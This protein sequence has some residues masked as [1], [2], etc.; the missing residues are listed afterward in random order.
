MAGLRRK[1]GDFWKG[2]EEWDVFVLSETWQ[3]EREWEWL[4][5]KLPR[6]FVWERQWAKRDNKKGR[7]RGG[8]LMRVRKGLE[9]RGEGR[10]EIE[11]IL[12][13]EVRMGRE[14]WRIVGVYINK[15]LDRKLGELGEWTEETEG[16]IRKVIGGDF[17]ARTGEEGGVVGEGGK[18][19]GERCR[20]SKD[21]E[22]NGEGRKLCKFL[23]ERGWGIMNGCV[24]GDEEGNGHLPGGDLGERR[25]E[26]GGRDREK[27][28]GAV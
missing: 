1:D 24:E 4:E 27:W 22:V 14:W 19:E 2:L 15:D 9:M 25:R 7:A 18:E 11:G 21:K 8:R 12:T 26:G 16:G 23:E 13:K 3:E 17:N 20:R 10:G 6:G 28:R 5:R